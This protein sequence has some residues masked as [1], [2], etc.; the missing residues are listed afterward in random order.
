MNYKKVFSIDTQ[1]YKVTGVEKV[2]LDIHHAVR[3]DYEAKIVGTILY[4]EVNKDHNIPYEEYIHFHN[5]FMFYN[6]IVIV[7]ERR[8]LFQNH[9]HA[10]SI[11][12]G[13]SG[14]LA[15]AIGAIFVVLS[16]K[17]KF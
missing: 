7:H 14:L 11:V 5:P 3:N 12:M 13:I 10:F 17:R 8:L 2:L 16:H 4:K 9:A 1:L 6:S 15:I